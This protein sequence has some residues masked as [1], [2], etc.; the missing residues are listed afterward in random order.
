MMADRVGNYAAAATQLQYQLSQNQK[1]V[2]AVIQQGTIMHVRSR[3]PQKDL[4]ELT[5]QVWIHRQLH[6]LKEMSGI[7]LEGQLMICESGL[8]FEA[9]NDYPL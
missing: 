9:K 5:Y 4:D 1:Q 7:L 3:Y 2:W 6:Q 8:W